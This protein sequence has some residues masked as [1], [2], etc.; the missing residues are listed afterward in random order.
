MRALALTKSRLFSA[1]ILLLS[2]G[3][4]GVNIVRVF[5][6]LLYCARPHDVKHMRCKA[7]A[8]LGLSGFV[9]PVFGCLALQF[10][11]SKQVYIV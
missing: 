3:P 4:L 1:L 11:P 9:D 2:L 8:G 5:R 7:H 10:A 6:C